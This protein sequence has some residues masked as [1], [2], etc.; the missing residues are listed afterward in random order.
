MNK[1]PYDT[2]KCKAWKEAFKGNGA[3]YT[4][5]NLV[6]SH[7][8]ILRGCR[9]MNDSL[10]KL[11]ECLETYKGEYWRFHYMLKDTIEYNDFDLRESIRRHS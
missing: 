10:V 11:N 4:L 3:Y 7:K 6:L 5:R 1:L 8:V 2:P 9:G